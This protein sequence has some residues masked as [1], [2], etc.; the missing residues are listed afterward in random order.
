MNENGVNSPDADEYEVLKR[1]KVEGTSS[2]SVEGSPGVD[3]APQVGPP[4]VVEADAVKGPPVLES[5]VVSDGKWGLT[6]RQLE[7]V[8]H[9]SPMLGFLIPGVGFIA[10]VVWWILL[11]DEF[12]GVDQHGKM[13]VNWILTMTGVLLGAVVLAFA[14]C[15]IGAF[16]VAP[17]A[18]VIAIAAVVFP[19]MGA[20]AASEGRLWKYPGLYP[21]IK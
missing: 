11:K 5:G 4:P 1:A 6:G 15:G 18:I 3:A 10:P 9:L 16:V 7:V 21:F 20:L 17:V 13:V 8:L 12:S 19:I 2:P 14:T